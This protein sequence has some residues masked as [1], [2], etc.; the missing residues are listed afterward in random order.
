MFQGNLADILGSYLMQQF[1]ADLDDTMF[2]YDCDMLTTRLRP[3]LYT[4]GPEMFIQMS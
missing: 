1:R 4:I 2:D 3:Y